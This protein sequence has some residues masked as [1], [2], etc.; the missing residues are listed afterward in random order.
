MLATMGDNRRRHATGPDDATLPHSALSEDD[1]DTTRRRETR[2]DTTNEL[3]PRLSASVSSTLEELDDSSRYAEASH[4]LGAGGM[5]TVQL[6]RD[7]KVGREV[8]LK[9]MNADSRGDSSARRRFL[10]EARIQGRL[11]HT[12]IVP[13]YDLGTNADGEPYFTMKRVRGQSLAEVLRAQRQRKAT[14]FSRRKLLSALSQV[15]IAV[16]YAHERGIVHRDIKPANIMFGSYGEVYLIDWGVAKVL[17]ETDDTDSNELAPTPAPHGESTTAIGDV[18]GSLG[19]M[20]PEQVQGGDVDARTD[21]Y[22]LGAVLFEVLTLESLHPAGSFEAVAVRISLG[23]EA[24]PSVRVPTADVP[25]ELE[26]LCVSATRV[27]ADERLSSAL[28]FSEAIEAHLDGDRDQELRRESSRRH[29]EEA[30][31]RTAEALTV[32]PAEGE[33]A[34]KR[35]LALRAAAL[36]EVGRALAL[37][38]GNRSALG[39]LVTLLTSPPRV[40]PDEVVAEQRVVWHQQIRLAVIGLVAAYA[41]IDAHALAIYAFSGQGHE[42]L[43]RSVALSL[44]VMLLSVVTYLRPA[45]LPLFGCCLLGMIDCVYDANVFSSMMPVVPA[46]LI[47]QAMAFSFARTPWFRK[48]TLAVAACSWAAIV[49]GHRIGLLAQTTRYVDGDIVLHSAAIA[50]DPQWFPLFV[51]VS[52]LAIIVVSSVVIGVLRTTFQRAD[53]HMRLQA[54]QLRQLVA[55]EPS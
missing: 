31:K 9:V 45:P 27:R 44:G 37:D 29:A 50:F 22:A 15:A 42:I 5:G 48:A 36:R 28:A 20:A 39:V 3:T 14:K 16:H 32:A 43:T 49:F 8:A 52:V 38:A 53:D 10:R 7:D 17:G 21:V 11:E 23:L 35:E 24:R 1:D 12:A 33:S 13:V 6:V 4:I 25:P 46:L 40:V 55:E 47:A 34:Q 2:D 19:T 51:F 41:L 30:R 26:A 18:I 54:W